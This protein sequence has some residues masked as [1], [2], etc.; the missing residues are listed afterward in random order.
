[1][2]TD[3][4]SRSYDPG[5]IGYRYR[6]N[7]AP[8]L[9]DRIYPEPH[10]L[11]DPLLSDPDCPLTPA[12]IDRGCAFLQLFCNNQSRKTFREDNEF[13]WKGRA[14]YWYFMSPTSERM[15]QET[16][17]RYSFFPVYPS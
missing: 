3:P 14:Q 11:T 1:M 15:L 9:E 13:I 7:D 5:Y 17:A 8:K 6:P 16:A 2:S 10:K 4:Y 12:N